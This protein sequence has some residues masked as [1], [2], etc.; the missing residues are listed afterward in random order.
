[1]G[2]LVVQ[3][4]QGID[5]LVECYVVLAFGL[6]PA[7]GLVVGV[8]SYDRVALLPGPRV[9]LAVPA[10][11]AILAAS[12]RDVRALLPGRCLFDQAR[13]RAIQANIEFQVVGHVGVRLLQH[14]PSARL[15]ALV[16]LASVNHQVQRVVL[17]TLHRVHRLQVR[18]HLHAPAQLA[19]SRRLAAS[20]PRPSLVI[21]RI[22]RTIM[23]TLNH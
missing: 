23:C 9:L 4:P 18:L 10:A 14:A 16:P 11:V 12:S 5:M 19:H 21:V 20:C 17:A 1:M 13:H 8:V 15:L 2:R 6:P 7:R 3:P 22:L